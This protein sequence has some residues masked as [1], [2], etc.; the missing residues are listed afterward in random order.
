MG[1]KVKL[2]I[3]VLIYV[4]PQLSLADCLVK[5]GVEDFFPQSYLHSSGHWQGMNIE[6]A[7]ALLDTINCTPDYMTIPRKRAL[8]LM[9]NGEID[10]L[11][12]VSITEERKQGMYFIGPQQ[13]EAIVLGIDENSKFSISSI[14]DLTHL[15]GL[16]S[17]Q[18]GAH[19]G[20]EFSLKLENEPD[21]SHYFVT[22]NGNKDKIKLLNLGRT[23]GFL[24]EYYQLRHAIAIH[25]E[26]KNVKI[27]PF[28]IHTNLVYF[29]FSK[30]SIKPDVYLSLKIGFEK[31]KES[32][33]FLKIIN[34][35]NRVDVPIEGEP[36]GDFK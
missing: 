15:G 13:N 36:T 23:I 4:I 27:H 29:A 5:V 10:M 17:I 2:N 34:K 32:G 19:Y 26:Y 21:F 22:V 20:D 14:D 24:E 16:I 12:N 35:Y 31:A 33:S 25:P 6:L 18:R 28:V 3:L 7:E 9:M 1:V 11:L 30:K 8:H